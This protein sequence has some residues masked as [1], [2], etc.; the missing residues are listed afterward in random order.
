M[1]R[2]FI[3][4][5]CRIDFSDNSAGTREDNL[6]HEDN[7][8]VG[9]FVRYENDRNPIEVQRHPLPVVGP[10]QGMP[11]RSVGDPR[12]PSVV[13]APDS[14]FP[15]VAAA[16]FLVRRPL[17]MMRHSQKG[18]KN[19]DPTECPRIS[20]VHSSIQYLCQHRQYAPFF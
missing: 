5:G 12:L 8:P 10:S 6:P 11:S 9:G 2:I 4:N 1:Y 7:F 13:P 19:L 15:C 20:H 17:Y 18:E 16:S 14:R 3:P